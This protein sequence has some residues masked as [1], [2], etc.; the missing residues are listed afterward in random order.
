MRLLLVSISIL[1]RP[2]ALVVPLRPNMLFE[3]LMFGFP[4]H[5]TENMFV[6]PVFG[7]RPVR[8]SF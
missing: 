4:L 2:D 7:N 3:W 5:Y 6:R 8:R 1:L